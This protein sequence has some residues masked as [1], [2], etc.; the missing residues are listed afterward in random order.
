MAVV[1]AA[2]ALGVGVGATAQA[3][4]S[5]SKTDVVRSH[6]STDVHTS[7]PDRIFSI[8]TIGNQEVGKTSLIRRFVKD[9]FLEDRATT[10]GID[11]HARHL[12]HGG[13]RVLL[14]IWDTAGQE[15]FRVIVS[16]YY[17]KAHGIVLAFD[18][19]N[20]E[21]FEAVAK[22]WLFEVER[23]APPGAFILLVRLARHD[24]PITR[25]HPLRSRPEPAL[26]HCPHVSRLAPRVIWRRT[27]R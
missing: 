22:H 26:S 13:W 10:I 3:W 27:G 21:T 19:T 11:F 7:R 4:Y 1:L 8:V 5:K 25:G 6:Q 12:R 2:G 9:E 16:S 24:A 23:F 18:L 15:R 17:R 20:R 14:N